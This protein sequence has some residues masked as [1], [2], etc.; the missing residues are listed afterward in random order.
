MEVTCS[1]LL[2]EH[3]CRRL[4]GK[5]SMAHLDYSSVANFR[6][7]GAFV[8]LIIGRGV[9]PENRL[10][11]GG[12]IRDFSGIGQ[13]KTVLCLRSRPNHAC[14]G[15]RTLHYPRPNTAECYRT[16]ERDVKSW[17]RAIV[18]SLAGPPID[19]HSTSIAIRVAIAR[20]WSWQHCSRS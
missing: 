12:A 19:F 17:L 8:N 1:I 4:A 2:L 18:R 10:L 3:R 15:V 20:A 11:R 7:V 6:D 9:L 13:P 16:A 14:P 5:Y